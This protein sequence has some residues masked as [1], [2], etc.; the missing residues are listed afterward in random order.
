MDTLSRAE[1]RRIGRRQTLSPM[2]TTAPRRFLSYATPVRSLVIRQM[3]RAARAFGGSRNALQGNAGQAY[4][5]LSRR[6]KWPGGGGVKAQAGQERSPQGKRPVVKAQ[7]HGGPTPEGRGLE[8]G[9]PRRPACLRSVVVM[10][11]I[12]K[13]RDNTQSEISRVGV[14]ARVGRLQRN[15]G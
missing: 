12:G 7:R 5:A 9:P 1:V 14:G 11:H 13:R 15:P 10:S 4:Q 6:P 2:A 3:A 8:G